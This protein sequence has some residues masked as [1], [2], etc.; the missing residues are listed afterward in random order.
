MNLAISY[1]VLVVSAEVV[2]NIFHL[3]QGIIFHG[4]I[5]TGL[6]VHS[7]RTSN[8]STR[9]FLLSLCLA[10][11]IRIM[12]LS[13]P[14]TRFPVVYWYLITYPP[15]FLAAWLASKHLNFTA[16]EIGIN[17]QKL[18]LQLWV[19]L[20]GFIFGV[21]EYYLLRPDPLI[22]ELTWAKVALPALV[23]LVGT[24]FV[25]EFMFRGVI[26]RASMIALGGWGLPYVALLFA[27]LHL[28]HYSANPWDIPFVFLVG[29]FFGCV[30]NKTGSLLGVT[31][32]HGITNITLYLIIP[33]LSSLVP[34][35]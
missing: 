4:V 5:L 23:L 8:S 22:P 9:N 3:T 16:K 17:A 6:I 13:M 12:S 1:L 19:A 7:S 14:L 34:P 28:I 30:V 11:L 31:L 35:L 25:E 20:T 29:L 18:R 10:P 32:S 21:A 27:S 33:F 15:L 24:G 2:T 26:Q